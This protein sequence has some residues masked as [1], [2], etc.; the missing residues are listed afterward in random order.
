[1]L[2]LCNYFIFAEYGNG[3]SKSIESL[4]LESE[5]LENQMETRELSITRE[6]FLFVLISVVLVCVD[7]GIFQLIKN[8]D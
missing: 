4:D 1:V 3:Y 8:M 2:I 5:N 6:F 7:F